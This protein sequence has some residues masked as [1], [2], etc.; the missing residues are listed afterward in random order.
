MK[1]LVFGLYTE[2]STDEAFLPPVIRSTTLNILAQSQ[3]GDAWDGVIILPVKAQG[4][5]TQAEKILAAASQARGYHLLIIHVDA[6]GPVATV[7]RTM[8]YEPGLTLIQQSSD[9]LCR[10]LL[11]IIPIQ[12]VEAWILADKETLR[13][14]LATRKS[15]SELGIPP[16]SQIE[17]TARPKERLDSILRIVNQSRPRR[18]SI[19]R[20]DLYEPMGKAVHLEKLARLTAYRQF[21]TD[22]TETLAKLGIIPEINP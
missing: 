5:R 11:P 15:S 1:E 14:E 7:A 18:T 10:D 21:T 3:R 6:D 22:L 17:S 8:R 4:W 19:Q 13:Q 12:E 20:G 2:G 16:I 9:D